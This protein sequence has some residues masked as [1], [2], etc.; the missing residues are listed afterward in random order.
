MASTSWMAVSEEVDQD[1]SERQKA[2]L[3]HRVIIIGRFIVYLPLGSF[4]KTKKSRNGLDL[5]WEKTNQRE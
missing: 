5:S 4:Y 2:A 1:R 3:R